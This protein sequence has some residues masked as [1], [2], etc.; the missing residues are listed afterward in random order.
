MIVQQINTETIARNNA[1][2]TISQRL[3][4]LEKLVAEQGDDLTKKLNISV[5]VCSTEVAA[6]K[7]DVEA[8]K[9][10]QSVAALALEVS[11]IR[12]VLTQLLEA[13]ADD[14]AAGDD[15][16]EH[17]LEQV[18]AAYLAIVENDA[19]ELT[20]AHIE[21]ANGLSFD[22]ETYTLMNTAQDRKWWISA[23]VVA[24]VLAGEDA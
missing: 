15:G 3:N 20:V 13:L 9:E 19:D 8:L 21:T 23:A 14:E 5:S 7:R 22:G 4:A 11:N 1:F 6:I 17:T 12:S 24:E 10:A 2:A 16:S 18:K